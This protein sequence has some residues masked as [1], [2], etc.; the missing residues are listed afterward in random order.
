MIL[1]GKGKQI[2]GKTIVYRKEITNWGTLIVYVRDLQI[3]K[4]QNLLT[5]EGGIYR[6]SKYD[7]YNIQ[8]KNY[9]GHRGIFDR[10]AKIL[11]DP[12]KILLR[13]TRGIGPFPRQRSTSLV[14]CC[15]IFG[16]E[17]LKYVYVC[18]EEALLREAC[19]HILKLFDQI[20]RST[21]LTRYFSNSLVL[22]C[23]Q[24]STWSLASCDL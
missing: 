21:L 20:L 3:G 6:L 4:V 23:K 15:A 13:V 5:I 11:Y 7:F 9:T 12:W 18:N 8:H 17:V 1:Y 19:V 2:R 24:N 16:Q 22:F 14:E 10:V